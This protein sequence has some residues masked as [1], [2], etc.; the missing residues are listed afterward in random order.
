MFAM[1]HSLGI[2]LGTSIVSDTSTL[3]ESNG[4]Q[5]AYSA[6]VGTSIKQNQRNS[7]TLPCT[8]T[9]GS[10]YTEPPQSVV[11]HCLDK[12]I[13]GYWYEIWTFWMFCDLKMLFFLLVVKDFVC[14]GHQNSL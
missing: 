9:D 7:L 11:E 10:L 1:P 8:S 14:I 4:D 13:V 5:C 12:L 3:G 6:V 2:V